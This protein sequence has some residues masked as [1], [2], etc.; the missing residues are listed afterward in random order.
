M[1]VTH[2]YMQFSCEFEAF[3]ASLCLF[4]SV[5][6]GAACACSNAST[7]DMTLFHFPN[8]GL[9]KD[10]LLYMLVCEAVLLV[11]TLPFLARA[12]RST[13]REPWY[14]S[15]GLFSTLLLQGGFMA[16]LYLQ[17]GMFEA[18]LALFGLYSGV[19][20]VTLTQLLLLM[21]RPA[22]GLHQ[23]LF[24]R[25]RPR[26]RAAL[27]TSVLMFE[28]PLLAAY[29]F[30]RDPGPDAFNNCMYSAFLMIT[31]FFVVMPGSMLVAAALFY[32]QTTNSL[33]VGSH[34]SEK[35]ARLH[36]NLVT[37]RRVAAG[38]GAYSVAL[39]TLMV[40]LMLLGSIPFAWLI[41]ASA[42]ATTAVVAPFYSA[43]V[44]HSKTRTMLMDMAFKSKRLTVP[45]SSKA[46]ESSKN[47][48]K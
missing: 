11:L 39:P 13:V 19:F 47:E 29:G 4:D 3:N 1:I 40:F 25:L 48:T 14:I 28:L 42:L 12:L 5:C 27:A 6:V 44:T 9:P 10:T 32:R 2:S 22:M 7:H 15:L 37:M 35:M 16:S 17:H 23:T 31:V 41:V 34:P 26:I 38:L 18:G 45:A 8:C 30:V 33:A 43:L 36:T 21:L 20:A 24:R 46:E